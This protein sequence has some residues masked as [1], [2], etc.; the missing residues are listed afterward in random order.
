[1]LTKTDILEL[2][3]LI[4]GELSRIDETFGK[5]QG[6]SVEKEKSY[7]YGML[8]KLDDMKETI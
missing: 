6:P 5:F 8:I 4:W 1:M 2:Q 7:W 3:E